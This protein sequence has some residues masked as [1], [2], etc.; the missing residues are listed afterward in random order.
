MRS[1]A[2]YLPTNNTAN[3]MKHLFQICQTVN[4]DCQRRVFDVVFV[5]TSSTLVQQDSSSGWSNLVNFVANL[6][7]SMNVGSQATRVGVVAYVLTR[8]IC[9]S[10]VVFMFQL[11]P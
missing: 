9:S 8:L 3:R 11:S 1:C 7:S 6:V 2:M 5:L 4:A 10:R